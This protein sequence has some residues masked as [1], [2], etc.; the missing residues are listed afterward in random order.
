MVSNQATL[1]APTSTHSVNGPL[2][3]GQDISRLKYFS[4]I[5]FEDPLCEAPWLALTHGTKVA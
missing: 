1:K 5:G 4:Y 2:D 3:E